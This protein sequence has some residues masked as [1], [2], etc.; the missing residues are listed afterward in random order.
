ISLLSRPI[1]LQLIFA[2]VAYLW[3]RGVEQ[4]INRADRAE[5]V[6]Q[7]ERRELERTIA[8]EEGV[9]YLHAT[10]MQWRNGNF[11]PRMPEMPVEAL[12]R[13]SLDLNAFIEQVSP[14]LQADYYYQRTQ[15]A[16]RRL[17]EALRAQSHGQRVT[18]P[19]PSGTPVDMVIEALRLHG[20]GGPRWG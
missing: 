4:A 10:L 17:A 18:I 14:R 19:S 15:D 20:F 2:V 6:A 9:R 1:A 3:V 11:R 12:Q 7:L 13:L 16:A 8:L 5:E